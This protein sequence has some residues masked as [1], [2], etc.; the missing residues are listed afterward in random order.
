MDS[1]ISNRLNRLV[2]SEFLNFGGILFWKYVGLILLEE[3]LLTTLL[4]SFMDVLRDTLF[5]SSYMVSFLV[6]LIYTRLLG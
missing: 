4:M 1:Y 6:A 5:L 3:T 2:L